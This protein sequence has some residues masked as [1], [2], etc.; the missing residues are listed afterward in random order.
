M[1]FT[2]VMAGFRHQVEG[3]SGCW[4]GS[5]AGAGGGHG[6]SLATDAQSLPITPVF[7]KG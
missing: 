4:R 2:E 7:V 5:R 3:V 6:F 1:R